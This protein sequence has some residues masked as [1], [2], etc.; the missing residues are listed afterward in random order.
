MSRRE[1]RKGV[2]CQR[3]AWSLRR[4]QP[5]DSPAAA[6]SS[7]QAV[8]CS[9]TLVL[10]YRLFNAQRD[11]ITHQLV[12]PLDGSVTSPIH[13]ETLSSRGLAWSG[14]WVYGLTLSLPTARPV[15]PFGGVSSMSFFWQKVAGKMAWEEAW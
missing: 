4:T 2:H 8:A 3:G 1:S 7:P 13:P 12:V 6:F 5:G 15:L 9:R 11:Q 14:L 10:L